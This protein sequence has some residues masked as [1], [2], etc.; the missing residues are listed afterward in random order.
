MWY[1]IS[2]SFILLC[3]VGPPWTFRLTWAVW[4]RRRKGI[5]FRWNL[6]RLCLGELLHI[7]L[8][9]LWSKIH[10]IN[11]SFKGNEGFSGPKGPQGSQGPIVSC[12]L[13]CQKLWQCIWRRNNP[14]SHPYPPPQ[15]GR[16]E[17]LTPSTLLLDALL[18]ILALGHPPYRHFLT[19]QT[20]CWGT[21]VVQS[22]FLFL[23]FFCN[24]GCSRTARFSRKERSTWI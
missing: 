14:S 9:D 6:W 15:K 11:V 17:S 5:T 12:V 8:M 22:S 2:V 1:L 16:R 4:E 23:L 7:M 19:P 24:L 3:F 21:S 10:E 20:A 13:I 18:T